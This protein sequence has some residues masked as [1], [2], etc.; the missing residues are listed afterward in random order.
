M[1]QWLAATHGYWGVAMWRSILSWKR[2]RSLP[3]IYPLKMAI[4]M[5]PDIWL[6]SYHFLWVSKQHGDVSWTT[7]AWLQLLY[8]LAYI[9]IITSRGSL[10]TNQSDDRG[11]H[12]EKYWLCV[13]DFI[14]NMRVVGLMKIMSRVDAWCKC[15]AFSNV[16]AGVISHDITLY[17]M[18]CKWSKS[19]CRAEMGPRFSHV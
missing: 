10:V 12:L 16:D 18:S 5:G 2:T 9:G 15:W 11:A 1:A 8:C 13:W 6:L 3:G 19:V 17:L 4:L 14:R 7:D